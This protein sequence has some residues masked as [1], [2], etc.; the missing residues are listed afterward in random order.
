[1]IGR[2]HEAARGCPKANHTGTSRRQNE[3]F[4]V[5]AGSPTYPS[6]EGIRASPL[7][8]AGNTWFAAAQPKI[9]WKRGWIDHTQLP[10]ILR[11]SNA[12][13]AVF[14]PRQRNLPRQK[15][16]GD[17]FLGRIIFHPKKI[18]VAPI[19]GIPPK[20]QRHSKVFSEKESQRLPQHTIWD[21]AIE[22]L[23]GAPA[24]LP[25]RLL[26]LTQ[27]EITEA[28]KF[29]AEHLKKET[30]PESSSPYATNFFF[31]KNKN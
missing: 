2:R 17:Y 16:T 20:Y 29:V 6:P 19:G 24:S 12:K 13:K 3:N 8:G 27:S 30:I 5:W 7:L 25:G 23:P 10:I 28:Q 21:H 26:P 14:V 4:F 31:I 18:P 15:A 22:L 9:D 11:A 1:M